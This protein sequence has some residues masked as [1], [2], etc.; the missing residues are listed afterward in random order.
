VNE[1]V[2]RFMAVR[3]DQYIVEGLIGRGG[4]AEVYR[5]I[6]VKHGRPVAVKLLSSYLG[7][8]VA[9][10]RFTREIEIAARLQHPN[11]LPVY[12]SGSADGALYYTMPFVEGGSLRDRMERESSLTVTEVVRI[13]QEVADALG[14]AHQRNVVHRDIKP[15]NIL[16]SAGHAVVAD[17]G[18]AR[19]IEAPA[20]PR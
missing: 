1:D 9:V 11:I 15:E 19:A 5:A 18:L 20:S 3:G 8:S 12:D 14:F 4:M 6:D 10:D 7:H 13:V 17:F 16:F 2:E